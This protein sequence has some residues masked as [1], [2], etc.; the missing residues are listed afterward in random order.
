MKF[1][2]QGRM[3]MKSSSSREAARGFGEGILLICLSFWC[4]EHGRVLMY[5]GLLRGWDYGSHGSCI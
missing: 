3:Q 2:H 4:F 1:L 5:E